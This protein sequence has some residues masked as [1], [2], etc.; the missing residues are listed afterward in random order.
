M[1]HAVLH[2][3]MQSGLVF[4]ACA[5]YSYEHPDKGQRPYLLSI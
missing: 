4:I 2:R 3:L 5:F 1:L